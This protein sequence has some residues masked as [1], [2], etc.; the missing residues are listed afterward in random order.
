M[1]ARRELEHRILDKL[2]LN[3]EL[4]NNSLYDQETYR[5]MLMDKLK[6]HGIIP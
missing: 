5:T 1:E 2:E 3:K 6:R 4:I